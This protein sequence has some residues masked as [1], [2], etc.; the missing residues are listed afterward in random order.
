MAYYEA[1][2]AEVRN[3]IGKA[4]K[5][6][7]TLETMLEGHSATPSAAN[8]AETTIIRNVLRELEEVLTPIAAPTIFD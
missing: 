4:Y 7:K 5:A 1:T 6:A 2:P 8:E 3:L